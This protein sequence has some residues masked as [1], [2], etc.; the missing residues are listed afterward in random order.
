MPSTSAT[1]LRQPRS[2]CIVKAPSRR[3]TSTTRKSR[4]VRHGPSPRPSAR[5]SKT[6]DR[7]PTSRRSGPPPHSATPLAAAT[8]RRRRS[9]R[10]RGSPARSMA[11]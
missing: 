7:L 9:T 8:R 6:C 4:S 5:D 11:S 3:R 10:T 2:G 1:G